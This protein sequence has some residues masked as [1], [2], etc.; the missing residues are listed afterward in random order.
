MPNNLGGANEV[1]NVKNGYGR[2]Y[3]IPKIRCGSQSSNMKQLEERLKQQA[4]NENAGRNQQCNQC[5]TRTVCPK[6]G[7]K[8]EPV[9]RSLAVTSIARA[10]HDEPQRLYEIDRRR[11][12]ILD[13]V[14]ELGSLKQRL[15]LVTV[16]KPNQ[17]SCSRVN[18][19]Y[20][21]IWKATNW[22]GGFWMHKRW[23]SMRSIALFFKI[24]IK[25]CAKC[26]SL[27]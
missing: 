27:V 24:M 1:V 7:A 17:V 18:L 5:V 13:E 8:P 26:L 6:I 12:S 16:M 14:K 10:I 21:N 2:N 22:H 9:V 3:L 4:R 20:E 11:I 25:F 23:F 19:F 15:T